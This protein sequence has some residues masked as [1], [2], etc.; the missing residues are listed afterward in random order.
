MNLQ[1]NSILI[2]VLLCLCSSIAFAHGDVPEEDKHDGVNPIDHFKHGSIIAGILFTVMWLAI[3][4]GVI[5]LI[6][7]VASRLFV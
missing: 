5:I 6:L 7:L 3:F 1:K 2:L 4:F